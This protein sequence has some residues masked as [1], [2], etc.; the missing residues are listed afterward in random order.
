MKEELTKLVGDLLDE[1]NVF[2][3]DVYLEKEGKDNYL[4][5]VIDTK[6]KTDIIDI[7]RIVR[8]T[9]IIDPIV[10]KANLVND[11]Y[12]LDVYAKSKGDN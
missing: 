12:I 6:D 1:E 3:D 8:I 10:E 2:I 7:E 11:L 5:V 9:K 4:R